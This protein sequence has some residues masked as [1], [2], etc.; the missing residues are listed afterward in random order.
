MMKDF[1]LYCFVRHRHLFL[2]ARDSVVNTADN[3]ITVGF[4]VHLYPDLTTIGTVE[5]LGLSLEVDNDVIWIGKHDFNI[6][7]PDTTGL[8]KFTVYI[9]DANGVLL[10]SMVL[11]KTFC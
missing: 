11:K 10:A 3:R 9:I 6:T 8:V 7:A 5:S 2:G 4:I 1:V